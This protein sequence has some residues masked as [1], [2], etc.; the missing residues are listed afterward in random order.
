MYNK[1][2]DV[3]KAGER[4]CFEDAIF[5]LFA[6][7]VNK[8]ANCV[9]DSIKTDSYKPVPIRVKTEE[10]LWD[11]YINNIDESCRQQYNCRSCK[12]FIEKYGN[13]VLVD[14]DAIIVSL[15]W[16]E[17][18]VPD[19]FKASVKAMREACEKGRISVSEGYAGDIF[20]EVNRSTNLGKM[21]SK[22]AS[23]LKNEYNHLYLTGNIV[24]KL[25]CIH[26]N[27]YAES[28][29]TLIK[30]GLSKVDHIEN[31]VR[32]LNNDDLYDIEKYRWAVS[33]LDYVK[34]IHGKNA[35]NSIIIKYAQLSNWKWTHFNQS[36][37]G[38]IFE[39]IC[40][41]ESF[42]TLKS[43]YNY[44]T[45]SVRYMRPTADAPDALIKEANKLFESM[46]ITADSLR[47]RPARLD[48]L[49]YIWK[50]PEESYEVHGDVRDKG[51]FDSLLS[52]NRKPKSRHKFIIEE[53]MS[54]NK[55]LTKILP[56]CETISLKVNRE[57][58]SLISLA[59]VWFNT[60]TAEDSYPIIRWDLPDSRQ[61][62]S[63][64]QIRNKI[65]PNMYI[66]NVRTMDYIEIYGICYDCEY[67]KSIT[68]P[69]TVSSA[70]INFILKNGSLLGNEIPLSIFPS[71][72]NPKFHSIRKVIE[73]Y[74]NE[75]ILDPIY[76]EGSTPAVGVRVSHGVDFNGSL[77]LSVHHKNKGDMDITITN[78]ETE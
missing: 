28:C 31:F 16:D 13:I 65:N 21:R 22:F 70:G 10:S 14:E 43:R 76:P 23:S 17:K 7:A 42:D 9:I 18:D 27:E 73:K 69:E 19:L 1:T 66:P 48:E 2:T 71:I 29:A 77:V 51:V 11:L 68:D 67:W 8:T 60:A 34:E 15:L 45:D 37:I 6:D 35:K 3:G 52:E 30:L 72:V 38:E 58:I 78:Y 56:D 39:G 62:V 49:T 54:L 40:K 55:F 61:P 59:G 33:I 5:D 4:P 41:E 36:V 44:L 26:I 47:R 75:N 53:K 74:S 20:Y 32:F 12:N 24:N 64:Y 63:Q 25:S 57:L 46:G 50:E